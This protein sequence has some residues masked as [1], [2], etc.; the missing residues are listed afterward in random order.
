MNLSPSVKF[1][2]KILSTLSSLKLAIVVI[3]SLALALAAA[4]VVEATFDT[5]TAQFWIYRANWFRF[6]LFML[7]MNI[8]FVAM[9]RF[10]WKKRHI[11]FL[12]AHLG[13]LILLFGSWLTDR[14]GI[15]GSL[16]ISEGETNSIVELDSSYVGISDQKDFFSIPIQWTPPEYPFKPLDVAQKGIPYPLEIDQFMT[17]ADSE[18]HFI[19]NQGSDLNFSKS[20]A[21]WPAIQLRITGGPMNISQ[22]LWLWQGSENWQSVQAG[23]A[24]FSI[25]KLTSPGGRK[26]VLSFLT[27]KNGGLSFVAYSSQG[28]KTQ[29]NFEKNKIVGQEIDPGWKGNI[30]IRIEKWFEDAQ[31]SVIYKKARIQHGPL[32]PPSAIHVKTPS[33]DGIW[34]GLGD[35]AN[36]L[37]SGRNVEVGYFPKRIMLPFSIRLDRFT[38]EHDQ[39]TTNPSSYASRVTFFDGTAEKESLISMN[40][41]LEVK[42][43]TLYQASY[44]EANPRPVTSILA[45]NRDPGRIWKYFGSFLI[46]L[47]SIMLFASKYK[48]TRIQQKNEV[49]PSSTFALSPN[50]EG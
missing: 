15:D 2:K 24:L 48:R 46:V 20:R 39:G 31:P 1:S 3:L 42:G 10:P 16:R 50:L 14:I 6:I 13:I 26:P 43:F 11:P 38:V 8:F 19:S 7:G 49:Y 9:S 36:L 44:E 27:K 45:V 12:L 41:P 34:L 30:K 28:K 5:P 4:T 47:G 17:H 35:R 25:G 23:P 32:A 37:L 40:E 33:A 29:G 22:L 18:I 21:N